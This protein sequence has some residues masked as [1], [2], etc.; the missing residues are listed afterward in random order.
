MSRYL[1]GLLKGTHFEVHIQQSL[2]HYPMVKCIPNVE[3]YS[4]KLGKNTQIDQIILAP[5]AIYFVEQKSFSSYL[6]G[7]LSDHD[8]VGTTGRKSTVIYNPV[9]QNQ[10][11]IRSFNR[12]LFT[13]YKQFIRPLSY[14]I[15]PDTCVVQSKCDN[16]VNLSNF[17][18]IL[19]MDS[20]LRTHNIDVQAL[21]RV[22]ER[23]RLN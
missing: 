6:T 22:I 12:A 5:W 17:L 1:K 19:A 13:T 10:E 14:V 2:E 23:V 3:V 16:V 20:Q 9:M 7:E 4:H 8:W 15:V 11:H 21:E 18:D